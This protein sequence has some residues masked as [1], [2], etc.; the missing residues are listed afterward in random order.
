MINRILNLIFF[1][2]LPKY[3]ISQLT[4]MEHYLSDT[5][6]IQDVIRPIQIANK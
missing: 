3:K 4:T 1:G 5:I 6:Y 2:I